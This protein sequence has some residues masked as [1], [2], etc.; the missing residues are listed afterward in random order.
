ML[1]NLNWGSVEVETIFSKKNIEYKTYLNCWVVV[2]SNDVVNVRVDV[3]GIKNLGEATLSFIDGKVRQIGQRILIIDAKTYRVV[4]GK[5]KKLDVS[6]CCTR[7][8]IDCSFEDEAKL[9]D[10]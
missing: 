9:N 2:H 5:E 1:A 6:I 8:F 3:Y 7:P 4:K 10:S